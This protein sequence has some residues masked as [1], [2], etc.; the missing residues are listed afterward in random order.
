[1]NPQPHDRQACALPLCHNC[2]LKVSFKPVATGEGDLQTV[3]T[4][5]IPSPVTRLSP[6]VSCPEVLTKM[7]PLPLKAPLNFRFNASISSL[8]KNQM[9]SYKTD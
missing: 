6:L 8:E 2:C 4:V 7:S 1:M 5:L 9:D 3:M